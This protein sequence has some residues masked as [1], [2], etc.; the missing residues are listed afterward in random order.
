MKDTINWQIATVKAIIEETPQTKSILLN[1]PDWTPHMAG[2]HY[3][4][5]L[6]AE[7]GYTAMRSYSV[8]SG[9]EVRQH[10]E[11]TIDRVPNGEVSEF[12]H[13]VLEVGDQIEVRGPIG[14]YFIW[15]PGIKKKLL[16]IGGGS[17]IVPLMSILRSQSGN[18]KVILL[19][20]NQS[21]ELTIY[22]KELD[23]LA[24]EPWFDLHYTFTRSQPE[25][26]AGFARRVDQEMVMGLLENE[27]L[28]D[29]MAYVCGPTAFVEFVANT[30]K[31]EGMTASYIRTERFGPTS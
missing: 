31:E 3:N 4:L 15:K 5:R 10:I 25:G 24:R 18:Q 8:A 9:L 13:E 21:P 22:K 1:L 2:Q 27:P 11:L 19:Y 14:G 26:W 29:Y 6:T 16:L 7:D 17:G 20:S 28:G 23:S 30:L 12:I